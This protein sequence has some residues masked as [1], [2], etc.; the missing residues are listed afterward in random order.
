MQ[1]TT[2]FK[3][4]I[5][6]LP[7]AEKDKLLFRLLKKDP[8]LCNRLQFELVEQGDTL[9]Q[10]REAVEQEINKLASYDLYSPG[11]LMM[12]MRSLNSLITRHVKYTKDKEGEIQLT[13]LLLRLTLQTH[14]DFIVAHLYRADT[15]Q[16]YLVKRMQFVLHK[17]AK[18]HEDLYVE[19]EA[20]ANYVLQQLH[21]KVAPLQAQ[22]AKLP[23]N[24]PL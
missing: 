12:D 6:R 2:E 19:Y 16:D 3:T 4:A 21:S 11:Y 20:D 15:L 17:L 18:L 8:D 24:W 7:G 10:R 13:L 1:F 5:S 23:R 9:Q 14:L 22:K